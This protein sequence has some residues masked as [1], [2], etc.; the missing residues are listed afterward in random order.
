MI[1]LLPMTDHYA[2]MYQGRVVGVVCKSNDTQWCV[3]LFEGLLGR[4]DSSGSNYI[5]LKY[6]LQEAMTWHLV[7][8]PRS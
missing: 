6:A 7:E 2:M 8:T 1:H 5:P 4:W 3:Q